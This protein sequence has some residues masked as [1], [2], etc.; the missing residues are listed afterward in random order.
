MTIRY[1][2]IRLDDNLEVKE[3][4]VTEY[5]IVAE[6]PD[7][8]VIDDKYYTTLQWRHLG[9]K[10]DYQFHPIVNNVHIGDKTRESKTMKDLFG[11]FC[12]SVYTD[13]KDNNIEIKINREFNKFLKDKV[14]AYGLGK[15][16]SIKL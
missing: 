3:K 14:G 16:V 7:R 2:Q 10:S 6:N 11:T 4:Q 1:I 5:E 12:I 8:L 13:K 15:E 9:K